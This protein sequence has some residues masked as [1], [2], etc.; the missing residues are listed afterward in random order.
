MDQKIK[1]TQKK[2]TERRRQDAETATAVRAEQESVSRP[3]GRRRA[4]PTNNELILFYR[5][6]MRRLRQ[7]RRRLHELRQE[8]QA[9]HFPESDHKLVQLVLFVWNILPMLFSL[10]REHTWGKRKQLFRRFTHKTSSTHKKK[11]HPVAFMGTACAIA[12]V[13]IVCNIYTIGTTVT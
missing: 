10:L 8:E 13:I 2:S 5:R 3:S 1:K 6:M 7:L 11:L 12:A 9:H 4:E